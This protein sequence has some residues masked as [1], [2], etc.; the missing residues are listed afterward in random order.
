MDTNADQQV[1]V[2]QDVDHDIKIY[3]GADNS[4][5]PPQPMPTMFTGQR[6]RYSSDDG[7]VTI[8][9]PDGSPFL[10]TVVQDSQVV[11]VRNVG[12]FHCKCVIELSSGEGQIGWD[13]QSGLSGADHDVPH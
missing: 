3:R 13:S 11:T 8:E 9:F 10:E 5:V 6:V 1:Q 7:T 2:G 4:A 12:H